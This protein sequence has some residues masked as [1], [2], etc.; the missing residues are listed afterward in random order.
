MNEGSFACQDPIVVSSAGPVKERLSLINSCAIVTS[1]HV[2]NAATVEKVRP[3][4]EMTTGTN[5]KRTTFFSSLDAI[6]PAN[7]ADG[8]AVDGVPLTDETD[9]LD[10]SELSTDDFTV[11]SLSFAEYIRGALCRSL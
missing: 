11:F 5:G 4:D 9:A 1:L 3:P 10:S 7:G 6:A 2:S 8:G